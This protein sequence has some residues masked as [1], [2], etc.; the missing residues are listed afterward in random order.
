[1]ASYHP[2]HWAGHRRP[3]LFDP[4]ATSLLSLPNS[5]KTRLMKAL[6]SFTAM[7]LLAVSAV[8]LAAPAPKALINIEKAV[9]GITAFDSLHVKQKIKVGNSIII[10]GYNGNPGNTNNIYTDGTLPLLI[11][12]KSGMNNNTILNADNSGRVGIGTKW[13][14]AKLDIAEQ[15]GIGLLF[16]YP[17]FPGGTAIQ[18]DNFDVEVVP[19]QAGKTFS[20]SSHGQ[21]Y[22]TSLGVG[23]TTPA[24]AMKL[25]VNG[26]MSV[27]G[28]NGDTSLFFGRE[29]VPTGIL[30]EWGIQYWAGGLNFWKPSG[31][32]GTGFGNN[33]F[34]LKDDGNV[35]IG[36]ANPTA[37]LRIQGKTNLNAF[38][39][40]A[41]TDNAGT[42][43]LLVRDGGSVSIGGSSV[44]A[45]LDIQGYGNTP[46]YLKVSDNN[47]VS[48]L[49]I[50]K[51]GQ[52]IIGKQRIPSPY[53][54]GDFQLAVD[55][56]IVCKSTYVTI[57]NWQD[58][59]FAEDYDLMP[60]KK[61]ADY[62]TKHK[63]LPD[64]P[65]ESEITNSGLDLGGI[66]TLQQKSIEEIMLY[67]VDMKREMSQLA[68]RN[69]QLAKEIETLKQRR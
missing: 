32:S 5:D 66:V 35:G 53:P 46:S 37:K 49:N 22:A 60:L 51:N 58:K 19:P 47:G 62:Y 54:H 52:V 20:V 69:I 28:A 68:E 42:P 31:S 50:E 29:H 61:V 45:R 21:V 2:R 18:I 67:L 57:T 13:P 34:F 48:V 38:L 3:S 4:E 11:Q 43:L 7:T 33:F 39:S 63:H 1:M 64:Y 30:G 65:S 12:S 15:T 41:V 44:N 40:L 17:A 25:E 56:K 10:D 36:T 8:L 23:T 59:V 27:Y 26:S 55:G 9:D 16:T 24:P 6:L 14:R